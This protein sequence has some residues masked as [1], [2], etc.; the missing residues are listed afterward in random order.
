MRI[1][2]IKGERK[3]R[4]EAVRADG[5]CLSISFPHKGPIP[6]DLVHFHVESEL[7]IADAFWGR[8]EAGKDPEEI[9]GLAKAA[10]HASATRAAVP[11]TSIVGLIQAE[12]AV[13]CFEADLWSG[14]ES[15]PETIREMIGVACAQS[16]VPPLGV[17]D[18]AIEH[19]RAR[20]SDVRCR[21]S[22]SSIGDC[23]VLEWPTKAA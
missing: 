16:L 22:A 12:R 14:S 8:V 4:I 3:D 15:S 20:L 21:W 9:A 18:G 10:G 23:L 11:D 19:V 13:E 5:S 2:I 17:S 1:T 7:A 6:H